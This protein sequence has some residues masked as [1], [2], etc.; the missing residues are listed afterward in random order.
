M[1]GIHDLGG[2]H[3]MGRIDVEPSQP[4]FHAEWERRVFGISVLAFAGGHFNLDQ[5]RCA[6][7][8]M[9]AIE[10]LK[11]DYY[12]RWLYALEH[13]CIK[14]GSL[15]KEEIEERVKKFASGAA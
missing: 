6:I 1:N 5:F 10:Y 11:S 15:S 4:I 12:A 3:G 9:P 13:W 7:E 2:R 8:S 14:N